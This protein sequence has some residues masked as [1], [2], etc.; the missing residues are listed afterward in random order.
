VKRVKDSSGVGKVV[1]IAAVA[2]AALGVVALVA[3]YALLGTGSTDGSVQPPPPSITVPTPGPA[4][5]GEIVGP[6]D[7]ADPEEKEQLDGAV[8]CLNDFLTDAVVARPGV[9]PATVMFEAQQACAAASDTGE[10]GGTAGP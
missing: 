5:D 9:D 10:S 3:V 6:D 1:A 7:V 2:G 8:S 4:P